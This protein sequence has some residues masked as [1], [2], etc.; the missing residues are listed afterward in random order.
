MANTRKGCK[1]TVRVYEVPA[2]FVEYIDD[3]AERTESGGSRECRTCGEECECISAN[4]NYTG[5][6]L[7]WR[8]EKG[9]MFEQDVPYSELQVR[10]R[11]AKPEK[12]V[13]E[14]LHLSKYRKSDLPKKWRPL[15]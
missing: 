2:S 12:W 4:R 9:H 6:H 13:R 1:G 10:Y 11:K 8:C 14:F 15:V 5:L 7:V 3:L